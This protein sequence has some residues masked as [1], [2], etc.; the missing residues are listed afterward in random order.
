MTKRFFILI[1]IVIAAWLCVLAWLH[2]FITTDGAKT[3]YTV[4]CEG[5]QWRGEV[6][7]GTMKAGDRYR[8]RPLKAHNEV[9]FWIAFSSE[10]SGKLAPCAIE[11]AKEWTCKTGPDSG[12]TITHQMKFGQAVPEPKG[13]ARQYHAVAKWKWL[14]LNAGATMFHSADA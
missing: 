11:N 6:C 1:S 14:L 12:R 8:F 9:I 13:P 4:Q 10:P 5:G 7:S 3:I 2:D